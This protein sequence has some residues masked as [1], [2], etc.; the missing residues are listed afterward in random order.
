MTIRKALGWAL[1]AVVAIA[2]FAL[3]AAC[4]DDD[5][6]SS[7]SSGGATNGGTGSDAQYVAT[8]CKA[9]GKFSDDIAAASKDP[10]KLADPTAAAGLFQKPLED[11]V[12]TLKTAKPPSDVKS[13]HDAL[14]KALDDAVTQLK[15][16]HDISAF[17]SL[18]DNLPTPPAGVSDRLQK[19]AASDADCT[20]AGFNFNN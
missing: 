18:G 12:A 6:S 10:S 2:A 15:T 17:T 1:I 4:G 16:K 20:K 8:I 5:S 11:Y 14:V 13:Y 9:A 3:F 19:A 7:S